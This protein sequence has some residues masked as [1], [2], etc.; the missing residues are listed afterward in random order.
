MMQSMTIIF[1]SSS[2]TLPRRFLLEHS[3]CYHST[4]GRM[5]L[6]PHVVG[7]LEYSDTF[8]F[9]G[10]NLT[11]AGGCVHASTDTEMPH[12]RVGRAARCPSVERGPTLLKT[13]RRR[14]GRAAGQAARLGNFQIW[15]PQNDRI[16]WTPLPSSNTDPLTTSALPWP[17]S[18]ADFIS[19]CSLTR[20]TLQWE[21]KELAH[22][23]LEKDS[24]LASRHTGWQFS[25]LARVLAQ[26]LAPVLAS[27]KLGDQRALL[28][29][30]N[31]SQ[32]IGPIFDPRFLKFIELPPLSLDIR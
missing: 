32:R 13:N 24:E 23:L 26:R 12:L 7:R 18:D 17:P 4:V 22:P 8:R 28:W 9:T 20:R 5:Q 14:A 25:L 27:V 11:A 21:H 6:W 19:G 31:S 3:G 29:A 30:Q 10:K 15:F 16:F 1:L 2:N